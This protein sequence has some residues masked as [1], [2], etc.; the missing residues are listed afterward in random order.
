MGLDRMMCQMQ[1]NAQ[2]FGTI[3]GVS[4]WS[5]DLERETERQ[6]ESKWR[7]SSKK[8]EHNLGSL[9][10]RVSSQM[11]R[12]LMGEDDLPE[13]MIHGRT[14]LCQKDR[15]KGNT[16]DNYRPITCLPLMWKLLT[17][18]IDEEMYNYLE[19]EKILPEG[20]KGCKRGSRGTKDQ[21]LTDKTVLKDCKKRHTN[22]S[23]AWLDYRKAY[24]L[25]PH[26]RINEC[27]EMFGIA[28]NLRTFCKRVRNSGGYRWRQMVKIWERLMWKGGYSRE[29]VYCHC[30]L[31]WVW[32]HCFWFLRR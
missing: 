32:C 28:E 21:L 16:A 5:K 6:R 2:S 9:H 27:M 10:E 24:G 14:V 11:N 22:L 29:T 31:C 3:F 13:W 19:R 18:V 25:V 15:Q 4:E 7:A 30:C 8:S 17:G 20:Q 1:K 26:S 23:M 12:I